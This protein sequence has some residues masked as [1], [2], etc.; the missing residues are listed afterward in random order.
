MCPAPWTGKVVKHDFPPT[1]VSDNS[2][3]CPPGYELEVLPGATDKPMTVSDNNNC[4]PPGYEV[5]VV[6]IETDNPMTAKLCCFDKIKFC[7]TG[8]EDVSPLY[9][10]MVDGNS[11]RDVYE[12]SETKMKALRPHVKKNERAMLSRCRSY[13]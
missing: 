8:Y 2:D 11:N 6:P 5:E 7:S 9:D 1:T 13:K 10:G 3:C 12:Y 4:C